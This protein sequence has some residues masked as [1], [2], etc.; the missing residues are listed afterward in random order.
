MACTDIKTVSQKRTAYIADHLCR[1]ARCADKISFPFN[2][3]QQHDSDVRHI[4]VSSALFRS[5]FPHEA[6]LLNNP[7]TDLNARCNGSRDTTQVSILH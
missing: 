7:A 3:K 4:I 5:S 1:Y 6:D 2:T